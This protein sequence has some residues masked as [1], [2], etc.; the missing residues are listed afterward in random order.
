MKKCALFVFVLAICL[1]ASAKTIS[2]GKYLIKLPINRLITMPTAR[3]ME[4]GMSDMELR[5]EPDG[6]FNYGIQFGVFRWLTIGLYYGF[7]NFISSDDFSSHTFPGLLIK[8]SLCDETKLS[9]TVALGIDTQGWGVFAENPYGAGSRY[10]YKAPG[11]FVV[12]SKN[13]Y[14]KCFGTVGFHGGITYN[15]IESDD[16]KSP[17]VYFGADRHL[18]RWFSAAIEYNSAF[19]D[20]SDSAYGKNGYVSFSLRYKTRDEWS[21][22]FIFIDYASDNR[23][24]SKATKVVRLIFPLDFTY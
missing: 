15:L 4:S 3:V 10:L 18:W 20:N 24:T 9:P 7:E 17:N 21:V 5:F 6:V 8:Y 23:R 22:E 14:C 11:L 13:I 12:A 19:N 2:T 16:D 1:S